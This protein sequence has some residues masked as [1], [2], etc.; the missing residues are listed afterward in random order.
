MT[1]SLSKSS[2][3]K[4]GAKNGPVAAPE[5]EEQD[6]R[7]DPGAEPGQLQI[8]PDVCRNGHA[9]DGRNHEC[10]EDRPTH[11]STKRPGTRPIGGKL[12]D[13][14]QGHDHR[15]GEQRGHH[16]EEGNSP[17]QAQNSGDGGG[18][19]AGD[20]Q[21]D[22]RDHLEHARRLAPL[23]PCAPWASSLFDET[24]A[25]ARPSFSFRLHLAV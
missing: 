23:L 18:D 20:D 22:D 21:D 14:V 10:E 3:R 19:E 13:A 17:C 5:Q 9:R 8:G 25:Q 15:C 2:R 6:E 24:N 12:H 11:V 1:C 7:S 16:S 4:K